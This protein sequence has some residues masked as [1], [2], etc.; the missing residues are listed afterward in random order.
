[1][2]YVEFLLLGIAAGAVYALLGLGLV[3]E[4]R[5]SGVV[6]FAHGALAML[7]AFV[8]LDLR[9]AG[10]LF[11]PLPPFVPN[12]IH[13]GAPLGDPAAIALSLAY[14]AV[15]G[16]LLHMVVF[17]FLRAASPVG[18]IVAPIG[19]MITLESLAVLQFGTTSQ[20]LPAILP[21]S[22]VVL[23]DGL[24]FP[25]DGIDLAGIVIA[26]AVALWAVFRFTRFGL[27]TRAVAETEKGAVLVGLAPGRIAAANWIAATVLAGASGILLIQITSLSPTVYSLLIVPALA[28]ALAGGMTSFAGV[29]VA[30]FVLGAAQSELTNLQQVWSWLPQGVEEAVPLV[31]ILGAVALRGQPLPTRGM[32]QAARLPRVPRP[33]RIGAMAIGAFVVCVAALLLMHGNLRYGLIV[34]LVTAFICLS[35]VVLTGFTGQISMMQLTFAGVGGFSASYFAVKA[36]IVFPFNVVLGGV[37]AMVLGVLVGLPAQR[38]RGI[39]LS[40]ITLAVA[41]T[42]DAVLFGNSTFDGGFDGAQ[43]SGPRLF[44]LDLGLRTSNV[45]DF[46][47]PWFGVLVAVLLLLVGSSVANL[48]RTPTGRRMLAVRGNER[49]AAA[50]GISVGRTKAYAVVLSSLIAG[51]GGGLLGYQQGVLS[52]PSFTTLASVGMLA[53]A[54]VGGLGQVR[55]ALSAGV[56]IAAGGLIPTILQL[57]INFGT[58]LPL[59]TGLLLTIFCLVNPDGMAGAPLPNLATLWRRLRHRSASL[60]SPAAATLGPDAASGREPLEELS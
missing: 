7:V 50:L 34:S 1:M 41:A 13:L 37:A 17:R 60:G 2:S 59:V 45:H 11:L 24:V 35:F 56:A 43:F 15:L 22:A 27:A 49:A 8:Y 9:T 6:N 29:T 51:I 4:Y 33:R 54:F 53:V 12:Q 40:V 46:P 44:G 36:G 55:G 32:L 21:T 14:A 28:V 10:N 20:T 18:R 3:L 47:R 25:Q 48:R 38:A 52:E 23:G 5:N 42:V 16:L 31:M 19:L 26:V 58:Y 30:G 39:S 57:E